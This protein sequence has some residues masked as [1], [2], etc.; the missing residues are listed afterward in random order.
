MS[1]SALPMAGPPYAGPASKPILDQINS[2]DDMKDLSLKDLKQ[3]C[4]I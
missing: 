1:K 2:P 4:K 3:V